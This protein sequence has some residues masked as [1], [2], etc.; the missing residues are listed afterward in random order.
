MSVLV[1]VIMSVLLPLLVPVLVSPS[2]GRT[3]SGDGK[4]VVKPGSIKW[5]WCRATGDGDCRMPVAMENLEMPMWQLPWLEQG[6]QSPTSQLGAS[7]GTCLA[8]N[9]VVERPS[10]RASKM[11]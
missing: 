5:R 7:A 2:Y 9:H 11:K 1:F 4:T 10:Y 6:I 3:T 8:S